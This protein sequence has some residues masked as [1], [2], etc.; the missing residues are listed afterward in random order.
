MR[1][2]F[3]WASGQP[4][5]WRSIIKDA[6]KPQTVTEVPVASMN[7]ELLAKFVACRRESNEPITIWPTDRSR[8][9]RITVGD[10]FTGVI[11]PVRMPDSGVGEWNPADLNEA[12]EPKAAH[13]RAP[14]SRSRK[15]A[16]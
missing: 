16:A 10:H 1:V 2:L 12:S 6:A 13:K 5:R 11:M 3:P 14:R 8:P 4:V 7:P 15:A 9:W